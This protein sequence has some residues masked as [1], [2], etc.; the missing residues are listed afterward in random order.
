MRVTVATIVGLLRNGHSRNDVLKA[1]P[2][3]EPADIDAALEYAQSHEKKFDSWFTDK[4]AGKFT[5]PKSDPD[6]PRR[7]YLLKKYWRGL[8]ES[9]D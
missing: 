3:L 9:F 5:L 7:D 4:W 1:Y 6:D 8:D 2:S